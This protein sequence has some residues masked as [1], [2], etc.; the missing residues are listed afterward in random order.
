MKILA[1]V[2]SNAENSYNRKLLLVI[3]KRFTKH[4]IELA[5]IKGLPLYKEGQDTPQVVSDLAEKLK[6]LIWF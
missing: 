2:G 4:D 1:I 5:E 3:K 6:P